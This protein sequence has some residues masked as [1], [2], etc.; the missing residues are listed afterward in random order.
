[1]S[2]EN[3]TPPSV[4]VALPPVPSAAPMEIPAAPA[5]AYGLWRASVVAIRWPDPNGEMDATV[6][7]RKYLRD[8]ETGIGED[9]P[10]V[11]G[12]QLIGNIFA[13]AATDQDVANAM[14]ALLNALQKIARKAGVID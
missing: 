9:A 10:G 4:A 8:P 6:E 5:K 1:M 12:S 14:L 2:E 13:L 11:E 7:W 3:H